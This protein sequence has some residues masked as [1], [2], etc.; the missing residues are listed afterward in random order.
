MH[1]NYILK[2]GCDMLYIHSP[3]VVLPFIF[4]NKKIPAIYHQH[5]SANPLSK[6]KF[7]WARNSLLQN[8]SFTL[9]LFARADWMIAIDR[10]CWNRHD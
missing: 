10:I 3:E 2:S 8:C 4:F 7:L 9:K 5:G 6:S 1:R